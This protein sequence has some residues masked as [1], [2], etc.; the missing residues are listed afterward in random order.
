MVLGCIGVTF[1]S[2]LQGIASDEELVLMAILR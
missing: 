1:A 2:S